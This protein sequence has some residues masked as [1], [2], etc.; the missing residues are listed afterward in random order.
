MF[1][2]SLERLAFPG[3]VCALY[4]CSGMAALDAV[5]LGYKPQVLESLPEKSPQGNIVLSLCHP[6]SPE[7]SHNDC[8]FSGNPLT[9]RRAAGEVPILSLGA[10]LGSPCPPPPLCPQETTAVTVWELAE[11]GAEDVRLHHQLS[12]QGCSSLL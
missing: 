4:C 5:P 8:C 7:I 9:A 6:L 12:V 11:L 3:A 2:G 10:S 1:D